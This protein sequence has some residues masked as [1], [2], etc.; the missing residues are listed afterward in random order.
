MSILDSIKSERAMSFG[1]WRYRILHWAFNVKDVDQNHPEWT[2]LPKF[3][4]THYCPLFHLTNLIALLSPV[5]LLIRFLV[6]F[7]KGIAAVMAMIPL[8]KFFNKLAAMPSKYERP[9]PKETV[10]DVRRDCIKYICCSGYTTFEDFWNHHSFSS[11]LTKGMAEVLWN[12]YMPKI[13]KARERAELRKKKWRERIIFWTNF[14]RVFI[15]WTMNVM[16]FVLAGFLAYLAYMFS[17]TA[18]HCLCYVGEFIKWLFTDA[19]SLATVFFIGKML[20]WSVLGGVAVFIL[21]Q[22]RVAQKF[23]SVVID[24]LDY[25]TAPLYIVFVPFRW[26]KQ[27]WNN[28]CEFV[29]M[30]YE[31]NCPPIKLVSKEQAIV[32]TIAQG[33]EV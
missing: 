12:E 4:Y 23:V 21:F 15:K 27:G 1:H 2:G 16:Y 28:L 18:W 33:E 31:E 5:I 10:E 25:I 3:L 9:L 20:M 32:E 8:D 17:G 19:V 13:K 11:L 24:G 30:F 29:S 26:V 14:S 22:A 6:L 7:C